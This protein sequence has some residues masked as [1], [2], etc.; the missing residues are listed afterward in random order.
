MRFRRGAFMSDMPFRPCV[1]S[2]KKY[3][4]VNPTYDV[5]KLA[6]I[7]CFIFSSF[8]VYRP[9]LH[10][11]PPFIPN[12]YLFENHKDKE[13]P[14]HWQCSAWASRDII[15]KVGGWPKLAQPVREKLA[16]QKFM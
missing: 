12:D 4:T 16:Y 15:C 11:M 13:G 10:V 3:G 8:T 7:L 5:L 9:T 6:D 1:V 14:E 2:I